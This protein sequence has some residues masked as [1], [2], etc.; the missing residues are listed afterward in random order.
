MT[1][2]LS[3]TPYYYSNFAP[4]TLPTTLKNFNQIVIKS[5]SKIVSKNLIKSF[6]IFNNG[7]VAIEKY[8]KN[9]KLV[10]PIYCGMTILDDSKKYMY[11]FLYNYI[12]KE[13]A[14]NANLLY[15]DTD[16]IVFVDT[17]NEET[18]K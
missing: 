2:F 4:H 17:L 8:K 11:D 12:K 14:N 15:M 13:Y 18:N 10:K 5:S 1:R 16:S 6:K 9:V 7:L 3:I